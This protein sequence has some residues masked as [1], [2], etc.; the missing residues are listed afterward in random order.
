[1]LQ[2]GSEAAG[3]DALGQGAT[4][5]R[6]AVRATQAMQAVLVHQRINLGQLGDLMEYGAGVLT[7]QGLTAA[8][9]G[10]GLAI[11]GRRRLLGWDQGAERVGMAGLSAALALRRRSRWLSL[12]ADRVR[13]RRLGGVGGIE[14]EPGLKIAD[15]GFQGGDLSREGI[16]SG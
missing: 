11:A 2:I 5:G 3:G 6:S 7:V 13:R 8:A 12:Q 15:A 1:C 10:T 16:P 9:A 14:L 4:G